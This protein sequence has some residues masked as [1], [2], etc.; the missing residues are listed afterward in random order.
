MRCQ[1]VDSPPVPRPT[2]DPKEVHLA[3]FLVGQ[4][5]RIRSVVAAMQSNCC[6]TAAGGI[7][8][9][10]TAI[11]LDRMDVDGGCR[12]EGEEKRRMSNA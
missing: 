7:I 5:S 12:M 3:F 9:I 6:D 4:K 10:S 1:L 2:T 8:T 11:P